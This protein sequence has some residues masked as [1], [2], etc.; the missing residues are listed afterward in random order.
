MT[1][2]AIPAEQLLSRTPGGLARYAASLIAGLG[3]VPAPDTV[4]PV[5]ARHTASEVRDAFDH[6]GI[7]EA[8]GMAV[9]PPAPA[10]GAV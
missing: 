9:T 6:F 3:T 7:A 5:L 10:R 2:V 4:V 8:A 1:K